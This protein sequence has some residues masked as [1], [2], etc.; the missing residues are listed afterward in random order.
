[1]GHAAALAATEIGH[2]ATLAARPEIVNVAD[3]ITPA[4]STP[5]LR[6]PHGDTTPSFC[7]VK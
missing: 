5:D 1:M 7:G 6:R 4:G 3:R 2:A